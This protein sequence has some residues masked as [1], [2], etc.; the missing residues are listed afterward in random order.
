MN[1]CREFALAD[2]KRGWCL[3]LSQPLCQRQLRTGLVEPSKYRFYQRTRA[4]Y[5]QYNFPQGISQA[6]P[7]FS[8]TVDRLCD[9]HLNVNCVKSFK[10]E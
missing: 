6:N 2:R 5:T 3:F 10:I 9:P 1:E 4:N 7:L 8:H